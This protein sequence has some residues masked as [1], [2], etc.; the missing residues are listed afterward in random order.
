MNFLLKIM[1]IVILKSIYNIFSNIAYYYKDNSV[2]DYIND[3]NIN[4]DSYYPNYSIYGTLL[5]IIIKNV[6][7]RIPTNILEYSYKD[8]ESTV[9]NNFIKNLSISNDYG[10]IIFDSYHTINTTHFTMVQKINDKYVLDNYEYPA[11][12]DWFIPV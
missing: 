9:L 11:Q 2:I 8:T 12:Y 10:N 3:E 5:G 7:E 4:P 6:V 1:V